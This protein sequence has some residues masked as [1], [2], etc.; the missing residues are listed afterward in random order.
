MGDAREGM[1]DAWEGMGGR[2]YVLS[3]VTAAVGLKNAEVNVVL[4]RHEHGWAWVAAGGL[5]RARGAKWGAWV[6]AG[7][8]PP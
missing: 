2:G 3:C 4:S 7:A 5:V 8:A 6:G 1:G